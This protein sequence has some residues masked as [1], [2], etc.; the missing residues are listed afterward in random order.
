MRIDP[1]SLHRSKCGIS[2]WYKVILWSQFLFSLKRVTSRRWQRV[3]F[4]KTRSWCSLV[5]ICSLFLWGASQ[6]ANRNDTMSS[7]ITHCAVTVCMWTSLTGNAMSVTVRHVSLVIRACHS[8][9]LWRLVSNLTS[10]TVLWRHLITSI[11]YLTITPLTDC[12]VDGIFIV[13]GAASNS[14]RVYNL[15]LYINNSMF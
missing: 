13:I 9:V 14:L 6:I 8:I 15:S 7:H 12:C 3:W 4:F 1:V 5:R 11:T 2:I 10:Y